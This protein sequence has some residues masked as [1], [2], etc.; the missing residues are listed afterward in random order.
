MKQYLL[1]LNFRFVCH[2]ILGSSRYNSIVQNYLSYSGLDNEELVGCSHFNYCSTVVRRLR[3]M[4]SARR[5]VEV[6]DA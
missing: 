6:L 1:G 2:V 5:G 4:F 3:D